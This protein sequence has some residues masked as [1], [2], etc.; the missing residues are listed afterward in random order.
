MF[1]KVT[2][3]YIKEYESEYGTDHFYNIDLFNEETPGSSEPSYLKKCGEEVWEG[4]KKADPSGIWVMQGWLFVHEQ[5]FWH[6][7][8]VKA[9]VTSVPLGRMLILDLFSDVIPGYTINNGYY[10]VPFLWCMLHNFGGA[11]GLYGALNRIN[12]ERPIEKDHSIFGARQKFPNM[13]GIGL[14]PE[15]I[16]QNPAVYEYMTETV[17]FTSPPSQI[18]WFTN[19]VTSRY[20]SKA[21]CDNNVKAWMLLRNSVLTDPIGVRNHGRYAINRRPSLNYHSDLWYD[22]KNVTQALKLM[23]S[24]LDKTDLELLKK[25]TFVYDISDVARQVVQ[26]MF[27]HRKEYSLIPSFQF[28][29]PDSVHKTGQIMLKYMD[30]M[31]KL[32]SSTRFTLLSNWINDARDLGSDM[33]EKNLYEEFARNQITLWGPEANVRILHNFN[34]IFSIL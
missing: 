34:R 12:G 27:D 23:K 4:V 22:P 31:E 18:D 19:Y 10:G 2:E 28:H 33:K 17:W 32:M 8:Q 9:M 6:T 29:K 24:C 5:S 30:W 1:A 20:S 26:L 13:I 14:T 25:E 21:F 11:S 3:L 16:E 7:E 15:G